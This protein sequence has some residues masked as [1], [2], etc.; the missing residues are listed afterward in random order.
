[1]TSRESD[2]APRPRESF[3]SRRLLERKV[4]AQ[5]DP[6]RS[7][8]KRRIDLHVI[9]CHPR[10]TE[11]VFELAATSASIERIDLRCRSDRFIER[12]DD[13]SGLAVLQHLRYG[14]AV[15]RDHRRPTCEGFDHHEPKRLGPI[16]LKEQS[17]SAAEEC[18]LLLVADIAQKLHIW[19]T[20]QR[21]DLALE[22]R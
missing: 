10:R 4:R 12:F 7:F 13:E 8:R 15:A 9:V 16:D 19:T 3:R 20:E 18:A 1:M 5:R 6:A 11:S 2:S 17:A 22:I 21:F 14:A